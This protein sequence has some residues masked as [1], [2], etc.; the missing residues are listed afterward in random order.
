[1]AWNPVRMN[2][3]AGGCLFAVAALGLVAAG[4]GSPP[5]GHLRLAASTFR[6]AAAGTTSADDWPSFGYGPGFTRYN[7]AERTLN[8][9]SVRNLRLRWSFVSVPHNSVS[10]WGFQGPAVSDGVLYRQVFV[11]PT[12]NGDNSDLEAV[13]ASSGALEWHQRGSIANMGDQAVSGGMIFSPYSGPGC[14]GGCLEALTPG[15]TVAW[16]KPGKHMAGLGLAASSGVVYTTTTTDAYAL[17][18]QTGQVL[19]QLAGDRFGQL[20]L[21]NGIVYLTCAAGIEAVSAATGEVLWTSPNVGGDT[22]VAVSGAAVF[23]VGSNTLRE[24]NAATGANVWQVRSGDGSV[25]G[26]DP[27]VDGTTLFL[28]T[29]LGGLHAYSIKNGAQLWDR[30]HLQATQSSPAVADG[31]VFVGTNRAVLALSAATGNVLWRTVTG[32]VMNSPTVANGQLYVDN[33]AG[34]INDYGLPPAAGS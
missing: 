17:N 3:R 11:S 19:W 25:E 1:M 33:G 27:A 24:L 31:V 29:T 15:G 6:L 12:G 9:Q 10:S 26:W 20:A 22:W 8:P 28:T 13:N 5:P 14:E 32:H 4:Q 34:V 16:T 18:A 21:G 30:P 7:P 2:W 23:A